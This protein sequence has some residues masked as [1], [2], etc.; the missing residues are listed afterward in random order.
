[1][2]RLVCLALLLVLVA[3]MSATAQ[4]DDGAI[5]RI[6]MVLNI[7]QVDDGTFNEVSYEGLLDVRRDYDLDE[8]GTIFIESD[9]PDDWAPN[10][11][12]CI[13]EGFDVVVTV[14]F[15]LSEATAAAADAN[16][17]VYFIG[18][19]HFVNE[20]PENYVGI[21]F[22]DDE[23]G[24]LM[25]YLAGWVTES[26]IVA[27]IYGP[28]IPVIK[29]FRNG[30][31]NG[32]RLAAIQTDK[33]VTILGQYMDGFDQPGQGAAQAEVFIEA[34]A[35]VIF[36]AAGLT[37]SGGITF[38]A[39]EEVYVIGVDQDEYFTTFDGGDAPGAAFIIS[40]ALKRVNVGVY[41]MVS[42]LLDGDFENFPGGSNYI[43]SLEN[44]GISFANPHDA[45]IDA[46]IYDE[47]VTIG[48]ELA[49]G[50]LTTGV[51]PVTGDLT[52]LIGADDA[53]STAEI[54][55]RGAYEDYNAEV[56]NALACEDFALDDE[57][58]AAY[59]SAIRRIENLDCTYDE[60]S[61][62]ATCAGDILTT[63]DDEAELAL[64]AYSVVEAEEDGWLFCGDA[65]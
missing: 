20:G 41:D 61:G 58:V 12:R 36:G 44:G 10:I 65:E 21:Q 31:E 1:M 39:A 60:D 64:G 52:T 32:V 29:R 59:E 18:V 28:P 50:D 53:A 47:V 45:D 2:I 30:F 38:A 9:G 14:G 13:D 3:P 16:P 8:G 33:Q 46:D 62:T 56:V 5:G 40:S 49:F 22:R 35:D 51:D 55:L 43:L 63:G 26:N 11:Q 34:G 17:D 54:W 57:T 23:G 48:G 37:G 27:G 42:A 25:G 4:D 7:G 24:F 6:C 15:Q 19:D